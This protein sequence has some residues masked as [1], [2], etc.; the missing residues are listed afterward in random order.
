MDAT[1]TSS[2]S[3][4][5]PEWLVAELPRIAAEPLPDDDARMALAIEL[6]DRNW[7]EGSGGPF[8]ALVVDAASGELVSAGVNLVLSSGLSSLHAEVT[9]L[10][11]AQRRL[12]R[13]DLGA[14]GAELE[15]VV[16]WA[17]CVMCYG[18]TMWSG[19]R[20][21]VIAGDGDECER[22]TG[23]DEGPMPADWMDEFER[24]GIRVHSG[25]RRDEAIGVFRAFGASDAVVYNARGATE[26]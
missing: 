22:L 20:R 12:G 10:S 26:R 21:L 9:A 24:R 5:L 11:L 15:L 6:A 19:V 16:N 18:A 7:R 17:T 23:F 13:W 25:V 4:A 14:G 1:P 2:F 8:G 3:A